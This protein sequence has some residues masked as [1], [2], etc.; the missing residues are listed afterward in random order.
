VL[1]ANAGAPVFSATPHVD[2]IGIGVTADG[3][4]LLLAQSSGISAISSL[5][6]L[7]GGGT[8][9][10]YVLDIQATSSGGGTTANNALIRFTHNNANNSRTWY[11]GTGIAGTNNDAF[12]IQDG[13]NTRLIIDTGGNV[14]AFGHFIQY[15][16]IATKAGGVPAIYGQGR[17]L[18][19]TGANSSVAPYTVDA[20]GDGSFIISANILITAFTAGTVSVVITYTDEGNTARSLTMNLSSIGGVLG[21]TAGAAGA[22]EGIPLHIRAKANTAITVTTTVS[23]FTGTYNVEGYI[24]QIG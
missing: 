4:I 8:A 2:R 21:T 1:T 12:V 22:F 10:P 17:A 6:S 18:A 14:S 19:Q 24:T 13:S 11:A 3:S 15:N 5:Q 16:N 9:A 7:V 20:S 23:I